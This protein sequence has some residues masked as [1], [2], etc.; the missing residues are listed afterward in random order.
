[1]NST[2][3]KLLESDGML[4]GEFDPTANSVPETPHSLVAL[5]CWNILLEHTVS[6]I[7]AT[8]YG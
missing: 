3:M 4:K 7:I 1:M 6:L 8:F 2:P 5:L